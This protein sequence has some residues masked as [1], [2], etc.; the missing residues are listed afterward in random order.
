MGTGGKIVLRGVKVHNLKN[1][2]LDI[3]HRKL[4]VVCGVSGSGKSSLALDTLYAEGQRRYIESFSPYTRQ[5]LDQLEKPE[6]E[7]IDGIPPAI[8]VTGGTMTKSSRSTVGTATE[9]YDYLRL[10]Y[11]KI[12]TTYCISCGREVHRET[13][14]TIAKFLAVLPLRTKFMIVWKVVPLEGISMWNT[15][16]SLREEG[17]IRLILGERTIDLSASGAIQEKDLEDAGEEVYCVVDRLAVGMPESRVRE[18]LEIALSRGGGR[19][20]TFIQMSA[21]EIASITKISLWDTKR[22]DGENW[23]RRN[24]STRLSCDFCNV[25]YATPEPRLFSFNSPLGACPVCEGFGNTIDVDMELVVPDPTKTLSEG[26]IA[27]W[28][29]PAYRHELEKV[30]KVGPKHGLP[31]DV[32]YHQLSPN[33]MDLLM[34]GIVGTDFAGLKAFFAWLERRKYKMHI[35]VF[36]SRWR[37]YHTCPACGGKRLQPLALATMIGK[38]PDD[39]DDDAPFDGRNIAELCEMKISD[40]FLFLKDLLPKLTDW[41]RQVGSPILNQVFSRLDFL[42][43]VGLGYLTLD[44]TLRTLSSG[45]SRRVS[46]AAAL[47]ASLVNMLYVLD[48]PSIGLHPSNSLQLLEAVRNLRNRDNTVVVVEHDE[49]IIRAADQV[50]EIGPNAGERGGEV[51]FQGTPTE[52]LE[53]SKSIT[54]AYLSGARGHTSGK[55]RP[56]ESGWIELVGARGNNL[57]NLHVKFP[58][59]CLCVVSGV[60]GA[61]KSTLVDKTLFP[62]LSRRI[63]RESAVKPLEFEEILGAGQI[64]EVILVDQSPIGRSPRSNPVT[65]IKA[66]DEI[67]ALFAEQRDAKRRHFTAGH[68]SFNS[69]EGRCPVCNGDGCIAIDMQFLADVYMRCTHC[70]GTRYRREILDVMYRNR[71]IANVLDMTVREAF[72]FFRGS[73]GIQQKL[74]KLMEVGLDYIRLGQPANTLSGG[75]AQRLKLATYMSSAKKERCLFLLDEPTTGLHFSDVVQ[76]LDCFDSLMAVGHSLIVVEHNLQLMKSADYIIDLGP[77]AADQ[78]GTVVAQGTPEE[79]CACPESVTGRFLREVLEQNENQEEA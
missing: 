1:I 61:G 25:D 29:S 70:H 41:E 40:L 33:A 2:D 5:F 67:R 26:A 49:S 65:Y 53:D 3:P 78:G 39:S 46:L 52:M 71:N 72:T 30:L 24:C 22:V 42:K 56:T 28:N 34:N 59:G 55:R 57:K 47:G 50:I 18:S 43:T 8:A 37:S 60:S 54:G 48:E 11:A 62:A 16:M 6:A 68:F 75:E 13:S 79:I 63:R 7:L 44:R 27:P 23:M 51:V 69:E 38:V 10:L 14:E 35:R 73:R 21:E 31:V 58:L 66:F 4:V 32:P 74:K 9:T 19:C 12:G 17:F 76:L 20:V 64:D 77:G 45:E 15:V 36:L